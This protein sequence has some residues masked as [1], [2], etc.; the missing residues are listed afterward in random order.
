MVP[1]VINDPQPVCLMMGFGDSA[2]EFELRTSIDD[3]MNGVA[4][5]KSDCLLQ[6]WDR[7]QTFGIRIPFPQR[8]VHLASLP[9]GTITH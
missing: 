2:I 6:I 3:P 4:N 5:V 8:D 1:R 9:E 7:F